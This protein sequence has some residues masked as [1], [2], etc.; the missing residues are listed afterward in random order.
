MNCKACN[1]LG[2]RCMGFTLTVP[3]YA[4]GKVEAACELFA[5]RMIKIDPNATCGD[6]GIR[7]NEGVCGL[8]SKHSG[9]TVGVPC[10]QIACVKIEPREPTAA[11][12]ATDCP[13]RNDS[14]CNVVSGRG[15]CVRRDDE[16]M[17]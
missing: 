13:H 16:D 11:V 14:L 1:N 4:K 9:L 7:D 5:R 6:C 3:D 15:V 10:S 8:L 2:N 12:K 17:C